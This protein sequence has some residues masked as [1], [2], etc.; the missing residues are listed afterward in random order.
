MVKKDVNVRTSVPGKPEAGQNVFDEGND[1]ELSERKL[2]RFADM[3]ERVKQEISKIVVGQREMIKFTIISLMCDG[4][5]LLEGVPG[6]AKSLTVETLAKTI[7]GATFNRI[8]FVPDMLP[9]DIIGVNAYNPK[10]G[11][12]YIVK[13]P[14][15]A[16]FI[17]ADE[18]N[19]APPKTQAAMMEAMQERKVNIH[20][21]EFKFARPFMVLATQNPLEQYGTYPLPEAVVDRFFVKLILDY[22]KRDE[23][24]KIITQ[25]TLTKFNE[26]NVVNHV[27]SPQEIIEIQD[28]VRKVY[29]SEE[30]KKYIIDLIFTTR[31]Q[32]A[33]IKG[34]KYIKYGG[35]PRATIWLSLGAK[36]VAIM[37]GRDYV[38]PDDVRE[39]IHPIL[40]H[41]ILLN[42]EG[43]AMGVNTDDIIDSLIEGVEVP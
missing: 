1:D 2:K 7:S 33:Q 3:I 31:G 10:T 26:L 43:K 39:V 34:L 29:I 8:Q 38:I 13:G 20:N 24:M 17:L 42:Y 15:F 11:E 14:I 35:S 23:E 19:R 30:V 21:K 22:P 4:N 25:N 37:N 16:N 18:I 6:L 5:A 27:I 28:A 36:A 40:R 9:A 32:G 12:F 41:R